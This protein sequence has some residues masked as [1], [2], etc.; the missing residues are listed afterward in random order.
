MAGKLTFTLEQY[1]EAATKYRNDLLMMPII[2]IKEALQY[3]TSRPGVRYKEVV[4]SPSASAHFAPYKTGRSTDA[5][6]KIDQR[7]LETTFGSVVSKFEPNTAISTLLGL[8][9]TK[10]DGQKNTPTAKLVLACIADSLS[11]GLY[12]ALWNGVYKAA[13]DDAKDLFTGFDTITANELTAGNLSE[14]KGNLLKINTVPTKENAVDI[15]KQIIYAQAQKLRNQDTF[16]FCT[17]DFA[18]AYNEGYMMSHTGLTYNTKFNQVTIEGSNNKCTLVPMA[19]KEGS[20]WFQLTPKSNMLVGFDQM[21]DIES[22]DIKE[23]EPFVLSYIAT[24]FFG[25]QFESIDPRRFMA[26]QMAE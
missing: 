23:F 12:D 11:E 22:I 17:H 21:G 8:G 24:M 9:A 20:K 25:V 10:G 2:G 14:A 26:I 5:N 6:L 3:M 16:L 13:G 18:D 15:A 4:G 7:V 19:N 1:K